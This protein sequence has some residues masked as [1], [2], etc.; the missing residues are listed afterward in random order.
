M[1]EFEQPEIAAKVRK[2]N[3]HGLAQTSMY[4]GVDKTE[5]NQVGQGINWVAGVS[6]GTV[7]NSRIQKTRDYYDR[8]SDI[9]DYTEL[10]G[11]GMLSYGVKNSLKG[12]IMKNGNPA[13]IIIEQ[14]GVGRA[15]SVTGRDFVKYGKGFGTILTTVGFGIGVADDITNNGKTAGQAVAHNGV[16]VG[17]GLG[18]VA[19]AGL[20]FTGAGVGLVV[21]G[22][23]AGSAATTVYE[24]MYDNNFIG[25]KTVV[26]AFGNAMD[27]GWGNFKKSLDKQRKAGMLRGV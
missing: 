25:T 4:Y 5:I 18:A 20:F 22:L 11:E 24:K 26:D 10:V 15:L 1:K 19:I 8:F 3:N 23:I 16:S 6:G 21:V 14:N 9:G 12:P 2:A 13:F 17:V 7:G 27:S